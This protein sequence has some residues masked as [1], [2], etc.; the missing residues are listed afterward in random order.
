MIPIRDENPQLSTPIATYALIAGNILT[1]F[2]I[3]GFGMGTELNVSICQFGL[4]P[5]EVTKVDELAQPF[6]CPPGS[7]ITFISFVSSMFMHGSWMHIVGNM[8]FLYIF[9][10]NV[11]DATG[12]LNFLLFYLLSGLAAA[13]LQILSAPN[14]PVPM[15]GASGAIGGVMG[16]YI[17][18]Y[19]KVGVQLLIVIYIITTFRVPAV[20]MLG[21]WFLVQFMGAFTSSPATGGVAFWAHIGGF[22][23]GVVLIWFFKDETLL[24]RHPHYGWQDGKRKFFGR[25]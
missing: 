14:S 19:P 18:L 25:D 2:L 6:I 7:N 16:A 11:E 1:W 5:S 4:I 22:I 8:W 21:Y 24:A 17:V 12:S 3:Q 9:G 10:G 20:A 13:G 15:V 23:G